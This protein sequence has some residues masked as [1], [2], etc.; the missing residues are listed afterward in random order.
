M[1]QLQFK[2]EKEVEE[3]Q[4]AGS[5]DRQVVIYAGTVYD[6]REYAPNHPGGAEYI[7]DR[8]G[9]VIDEDFEEAEHTKSAH[10]VLRQLPV[11]GTVLSLMDNNSTSSNETKDRQEFA[12]A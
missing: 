11:V 3:Y 12:G 7:T 9:K 4:R 5:E 1:T 10:N 2:D 6:V 8:L